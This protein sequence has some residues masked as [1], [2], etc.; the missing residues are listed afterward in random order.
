MN[1]NAL[2]VGVI[3][4]AD[5]AWRRMIPGMLAH[6]G[7]RLAAVASRD[8]ERARRFAAEFD[9]EPVV[10]YEQLLADDEVAAV[11]IPLPAMLRAEWIERALLAGKHVFAE[12]PLTGSHFLTVELSRLARERGLVLLENTMFLQHSQHRKVAELLAEGEIGELRGLSCAFTI[13]PR[14]AADIRY[15]PEVGGGA[16]LDVGW[17]PVRTAM[18][19]LGPELTVEGVL[20]RYDRPRNV[21]V[22]GSALMVDGQGVPAALTFGMEHSYRAE[23]ELYGSLGRVAV[24]RAFSPPA[25]YRPVVRVSR[26]DHE[27]DL[28]LPADDQLMSMMDMFVGAVRGTTDLTS[29]TDETIRLALLLEQ[30]SSRAHAVFTDPVVTIA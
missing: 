26:R 13:P 2:A 15:Q 23:Y 16:L 21:I 17:Y 7:I 1:A 10:G 20:L 22:S 11:Y 4:C 6:P 19:F 27:Y 5:I 24:N 3:G 9:C 14:P 8:A 30:M 25:T 28:P 18:R 12:K 29:V